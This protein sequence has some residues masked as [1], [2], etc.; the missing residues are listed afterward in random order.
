MEGDSMKLKCIGGWRDG[1]VF[2]TDRDY[3]VG[4]AVQLLDEDSL[5]KITD[6]DPNEIVL[7]DI[8]FT[9]LTYIVEVFHFPHSKNYYFLR[10]YN[11]TAEETIRFQFDK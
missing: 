9:K 2:K 5:P 10:P 4:D 11:W 6:F 8:T 3:K 7:T 1:F